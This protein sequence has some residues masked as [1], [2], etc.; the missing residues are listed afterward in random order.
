MDN[1]KRDKFYKQVKKLEGLDMT[2]GDRQSKIA[3]I[4]RQRHRIT[5]NELAELLNISRETIRRDLSQLAKN[6][7]VQKFHGGASLPSTLGEGPFRDRM[8]EN[9]K[10]KVQVASR[11]AKLMSPGE[12]ILI[13][14]GSTSV[15]FAEKLAELTN[16]T[17]VTNSTEI[18][19]I[20]SHSHLQSGVF[21][22]GGQFN[23]DNL[24][25]VGNFAISQVQLFRAHHAILTIGALD[26]ITGVMDF[27]IEEAQ[28]AQAMIAQAD[29]LTIIADYSKLDRIASFKVCS[30]DQ[31]TNL[32][33]DKPPPDHIKTALV[34]ANVNILIA[35]L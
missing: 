23:S 19:R 13:D 17:V 25:T 34:E 28:L 9:V 15:F 7:K 3:N 27:S 30:L 35:D 10:A 16:L 29:S 22:L 8:G 2:P 26:A 33:C 32:V 20:I 4:V 12:T 21:L 1:L 5:V 31:V 14:T 11:A 6:G 18:A 24:Q